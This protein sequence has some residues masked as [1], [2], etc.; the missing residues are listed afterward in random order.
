MRNF[1]SIFVMTVLAFTAKAQQETMT[2]SWLTSES[3][4]TAYGYGA[5]ATFA[6]FMEFHQEDLICFKTTLKSIV[7]IEQVQFHIDSAAIPAVSGCKVIIMQGTDIESA[8]VRHT[9]NVTSWVKFWNTVDLDSTYAV[10]LDQRLYIGYEVVISKEAYPLT[11][12]TGTEPKQAWIGLRN[13]Q[14]VFLYSNYASASRAILIKAR[15]VAEDAPD[16]VIAFTEFSMDKYVQLGSSVRGT[17]K[18][19]GK[20]IITSFN[21]DYEVNGE[22][23]PTETFDE[24]NIAP[25]S[26]HNFVIPYALDEEKPYNIVVTVSEPNEVVD[27]VIGVTTREASTIVFS[28]KVQRVVLHETFTSST[29]PPCK[30]GNERLTSILK[31]ADVNKWACIKYQWAAP[32]SGDP[33]YTAECNTRAGFYGGFDGIPHLVCDGGEFEDHPGY[34]T[35]PIFNQL[36]DIPALATTTGT[37]TINDQKVDLSVTINPVTNIDNP[38]LRFFAAIVEKETFRNVK[39]N[40]EKVFNYVLKKFMTNVNGDAVEPFVINIPITCDKSY[41]FKGSYRLPPN[42]QS[43]L[44]NHN[45]ENS[46]EDFSALMVVYWLQDIVTKEVYQA[47]KADPN[48]SYQS[49][50]SVEDIALSPDKVVIYP[51]PAKDN[52]NILAAEPIKEITIHNLLGQKM[53]VYTGNITTIPVSELSNGLYIIT[54]KTDNHVINQKFVKQ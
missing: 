26:S 27:G 54:I 37:A 4:A 50:V 33:Y 6:A 36:A 16:D 42:G 22:S 11:V 38:N 31:A 1:I 18:N 40:G 47:G 46:V 15:A 23:F 28:E 29:C 49:K 2:I 5:A 32:G 9:Q 10:D 24:L 52:L 20:T 3:K 25:A 41:T 35:I 53:G 19:L 14:G 43:N 21:V 45:T 30:A 13:S 17:I 7:G 8:T 48:P 51:N 12:A 39:T 34:Y 44:I